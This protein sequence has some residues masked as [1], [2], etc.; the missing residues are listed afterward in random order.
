[1]GNFINS[2]NERWAFYKAYDLEFPDEE[3]LRNLK[4]LILPGSKYSVY[5]DTLEWIEPLK[6]FVRNV[7]YNY[8]NIKMVG[9]CFGH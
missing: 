6:A 5:D 7:Y 4:G 8:E 1:M 9:I 2:G 3:V